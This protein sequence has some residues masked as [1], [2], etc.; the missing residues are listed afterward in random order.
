MLICRNRGIRVKICF[1]AKISISIVIYSI[2]NI[3]VACVSMSE[4]VY[5]SFVYLTFTNTGDHRAYRTDIGKRCLLR[6]EGKYT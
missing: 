5:C 1:N 4:F 6:H 2:Y 3:F